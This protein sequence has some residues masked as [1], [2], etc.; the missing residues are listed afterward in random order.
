MRCTPAVVPRKLFPL[1]PCPSAP[2]ATGFLFDPAFTVFHRFSRRERIQI[3]FPPACRPS[4]DGYNSQRAAAFDD[5][6]NAIF[7]ALPSPVRFLLPPIVPRSF[8]F[9][10]EERSRNDGLLFGPMRLEHTEER[11][12]CGRTG[13]MAPGNSALTIGAPGV[14]GFNELDVWG[15]RQF[16]DRQLVSDNSL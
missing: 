13:L 2:T 12:Y 4:V 8:F 6:S 7:R 15:G 1:I 3:F 10:V 16:A 14:T 9:V 5:S 11:V